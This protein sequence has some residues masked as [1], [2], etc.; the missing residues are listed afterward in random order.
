MPQRKLAPAPF[1]SP[2]RWTLLR[3]LHGDDHDHPHDAAQQHGRRE[4][5]MRILGAQPRAA[6]GP[7][8]LRRE[9]GREEEPPASL[10]A[11]ARRAERRG[12]E[13]ARASLDE[14]RADDALAV[15]L[16]ARLAGTAERADGAA[17]PAV[18]GVGLEDEVLGDALVGAVRGAV[19]AEPM[20]LIAAA[21]RAVLAQAHVAK[22]LVALRAAVG[23]RRDV[24]A[25]VAVEV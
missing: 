20:A 17:A 11:A 18:V 12:G 10:L 2:A 1:L 4:R 15:A 21:R 9:H 14:A 13:V 5:D 23:Q 6:A 16:R 19:W 3:G 22:V 7:A 8:A 25:R 24:V